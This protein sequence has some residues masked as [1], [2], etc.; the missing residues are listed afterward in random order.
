MTPANFAACFWVSFRCLGTASPSWSDVARAPSVT[1]TCNGIDQSCVARRCR[2]YSPCQKY[3]TMFTGSRP[4]SV[5]PAR[6]LWFQGYCH[7]DVWKPVGLKRRDWKA[8]SPA[9]EAQDTPE[10]GRCYSPG[11]DNYGPELL[12]TLKIFPKQSYDTR[13]RWVL[14]CGC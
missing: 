4:D 5:W 13:A 6:S 8:G 3:F 2:S 7:A 1:D 10:D 11:S 9:K 12:P 14:L